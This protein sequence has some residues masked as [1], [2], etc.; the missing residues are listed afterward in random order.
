MV[1]FDFFKFHFKII[2]SLREEQRRRVQDNWVLV[3]IL[4]PKRSE[5]TGD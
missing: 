1:P 2:V 5:M 3:K 4:G